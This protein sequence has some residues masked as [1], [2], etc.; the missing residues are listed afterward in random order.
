M[1]GT[2]TLGLTLAFALCAMLCYAFD[3]RGEMPLA[4]Y[5]KIFLCLSFVMVLGASVYLY[6]LIFTNRFD[7]AYVASYSSKELPVLYKISAFWAGQQGSFLLWLFLHAL[8][9]IVLVC[10][11]NLASLGLAFYMALQSMLA[12]FVLAKDPFALQPV[13]VQDGVG[14]NPLLMDPWMAIHPPVVFIGY[15]MLAVPFVYCLTALIKKQEAK[16]WLESARQW[17]LVAWSFLGAGIFIGGYWSYKVLGWGGFWGWDPVE[18]SSLVPWL[19]GAVFIHVLRVARVRPAALSLVHLAAIFTFSLVLYATFLTRSGILGDFSVHAFGGESIGMTLIVANAIVLLTGL[20]ILLVYA[21]NLPKGEL[22]PAHNSREFSLLLGSLII[23]FLAALIFLGM[24]MPLLT[25][26]AGKSAAVDTS[27]Y[28]RTTMPLAIAMMLVLMFACLHRYGKHIVIPHS[29]LIALSLLI[30]GGAAFFAG[31]REI[32]PI[33]LAAVSLLAVV[34]SLV[35]WRKQ[36]MGLGGMIAHVGLGLSLFAMVL[37]GS[38]SQSESQEMTPNEPVQMFGH[39]IIFQGQQ[40]T[41]D[42]KAKYYV[43]TVD[44]KEVRAL[45]KLHANGEDAA[46]EPAIEHTLFGD[47][48]IAPSPAKKESYEL[49]LKQGQYGMGNLFAYRYE[50][51]TLEPQDDG[52]TLVTADVAVT[53]GTT[54][55][56]AKPTI[57]ATQDGGTSQPVEIMN[58]KARLRLTGVS[59][60]QKQIRLE[61]LPSLAEETSAKVTATVSAKPFIWL[62]WLG[63]VLV[64][65]GGFIAV[66]K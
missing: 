55:E 41:D 33:L 65:A 7:I 64:C 8:I 10:K 44:G 43:Y 58:G 21:K 39:T 40:F 19:I 18:N 12:I 23:V 24:S 30:G 59:G 45:T 46:R 52:K 49:I 14:L 27:F 36:G 60:N 37:A 25:Q 61:L 50:G 20:L 3:G 4:K 9:G 26:L 28:V 66:K 15:A 47:I 13:V 34:A 35:S 51:V 11:K 53:D 29:K 6:V 1:L 16:A 31:V 5:G 56:H 63:S 22:Y 62:L 38:G 42:F 54:V 32:L 48:Y 2:I 57:L 17:A